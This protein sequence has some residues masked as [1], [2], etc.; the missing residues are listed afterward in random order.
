MHERKSESESECVG[1][2]EGEGEGADQVP[3]VRREVIKGRIKCLFCE[4]T[5]SWRKSCIR[6]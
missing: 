6:H 4:R 3:D 2:D 5:F 1:E